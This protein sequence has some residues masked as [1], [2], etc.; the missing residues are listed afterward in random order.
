MD[1]PS[2]S[3]VISMCTPP[4]VLSVCLMTV[5]MTQW[6]FTALSLPPISSFL[7]L[8]FINARHLD[9]VLV[10]FAAFIIFLTLLHGQ[11]DSYFDV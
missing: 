3:Q 8:P 4:I 6:L 10:V 1:E 2:I 9:L 11:D 7:P 5:R